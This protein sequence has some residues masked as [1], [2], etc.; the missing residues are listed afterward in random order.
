ML[1]AQRHVCAKC[2]IHLVSSALGQAE[3]ALG[4]GRVLVTTLTMEYLERTSNSSGASKFL[5][6]LFSYALG[7][8]EESGE[9]ELDPD[10]IRGKGPGR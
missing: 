1:L 4:D 2:V 5:T 3:Y 6:S 7:G 9:L 8:V 10:G